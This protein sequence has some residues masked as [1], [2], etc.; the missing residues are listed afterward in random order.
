MDNVGIIGAGAVGS[1]IGSVMLKHLKNRFF[2]VAKGSRAQKIKQGLIVNGQ[3]IYPNVTSSASDIQ[4]NILFVTV[5]NY[6][7]IDAIPDIKSAIN[8]ETIIIS[9][10]NGVTAVDELMHAFPNNKVLYG[11]VMRTDA[12]RLSD[13]N[14]TF[15]TLGEIQFGEEINNSYSDTVKRVKNVLEECNI[16][17]CIYPDMKRMLWKKWMVNVGAN[18]ISLLT[19]A[20]FKYFRRFDEISKALDLAM[21]EIVDVAIKMRVNLTVEDKEKMIETLLNYPPEKRTSMLQD[22]EAKRKTE[23]DYFGGTVVNLGRCC[24]VPTPVN[25]ILYYIVKAREKVNIA[26]YQEKKSI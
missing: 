10:L 24:G 9:L 1:A 3:K 12:N 13:E 15:A 18:Q 8:S 20:K 25:E 16:N 11:I 7:L 2:F 23:I 22:L 4:L 19:A 6:A 26:E 14:V 21:Q 5:K 17:H